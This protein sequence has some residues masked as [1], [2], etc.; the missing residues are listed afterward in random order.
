LLNYDCELFIFQVLFSLVRL[1]K[2][3]LQC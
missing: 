1:S 2:P 3:W